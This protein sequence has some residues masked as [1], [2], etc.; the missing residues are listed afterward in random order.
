MTD[1]RRAGY[2]P[3]GVCKK[4][5][6]RSPQYAAT[7]V[8]D[9]DRSLRA[10][11]WQAVGWTFS[12]P[13]CLA[14][15]PSRRPTET[16]TLQYAYFALLFVSGETARA[17][18]PQPHCVYS[19]PSLKAAWTRDGRFHTRSWR[20]PKAVRIPGCTRPVYAQR[21]LVRCA[22]RRHIAQERS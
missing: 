22:M 7:R 15:S 10:S 16:S 20:G 13:P 19:P 2:F 4:S 14:Q 5:A 17:P 21:S 18:R 9:R 12:I 6:M 11:T 3:L 8:N 1:N